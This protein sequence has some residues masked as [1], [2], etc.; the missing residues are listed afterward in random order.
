MEDSI[1]V[2]VETGIIGRRLEVESGIASLSELCRMKREWD[3]IFYYS[4]I[5]KRENQGTLIH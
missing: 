4:I 2:R 3:T 5:K 1:A